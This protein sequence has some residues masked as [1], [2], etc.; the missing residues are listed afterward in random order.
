M[1][2]IVF[3][4]QKHRKYI[5]ICCEGL[6][7]EFLY[8]FFGLGPAPRNFTKLLEIPIAILRLFYVNSTIH[9]LPG[10]SSLK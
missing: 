8:L 4:H 9:R 5:W 3:L 1:L 2:T 6:Q 7:Y 10:R